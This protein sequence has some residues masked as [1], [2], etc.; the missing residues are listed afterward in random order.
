VTQHRRAASLPPD[1][2]RDMVPPL[3]R[4]ELVEELAAVSHA[5]Y[6]RQKKA[7][8]EPL[9]PGVTEDDAT[10]HDIERAEDMVSRLEELDIVSWE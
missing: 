1:T 10:D 2:F 5:T 9:P 3:S 7:K 6:V 8:G 4:S